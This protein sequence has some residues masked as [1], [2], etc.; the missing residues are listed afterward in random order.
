[1]IDNKNEIKKKIFELTTEYYQ[2]EHSSREFIPGKTK[3]PYSG[4]V[5]NQE[6]LIKLLN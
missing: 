5:F 4:R 6:E 3:V 1:M 2:I